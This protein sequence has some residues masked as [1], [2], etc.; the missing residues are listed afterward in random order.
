MTNF[1]KLLTV[2]NL[3]NPPEEIE[4]AMPE[5]GPGAASDMAGNDSTA[6]EL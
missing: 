6:D 3:D 4:A 2:W 1:V 5:L